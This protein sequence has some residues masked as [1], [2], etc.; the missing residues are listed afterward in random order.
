MVRGDDCELIQATSV[1]IDY[2]LSKSQT[3]TC[4]T[5]KSLLRSH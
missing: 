4:H 5:Q 1:D 3:P 2:E